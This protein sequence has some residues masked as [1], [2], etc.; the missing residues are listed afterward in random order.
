M[1][2]KITITSLLLSCFLI[3]FGTITNLTGK[4][5]GLLK[6]DQG[7]EFPLL[8]NFKIN[9]DQLTGTAKTPEGD[10]PI[11]DGKII[12]GTFTFNVIVK[13]LEIDHSGKFYGD[14]VGV[15]ISLDDIRSHATLKRVP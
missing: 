1:K 2:K 8:Y 13:G 5:G 10:M 7:N 12:N 9:G 11:N 4:W 15:D 3:S 14:S 6:T